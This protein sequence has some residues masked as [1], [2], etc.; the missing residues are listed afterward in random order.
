ML[1]SALFVGAF[2]LSFL[3]APPTHAESQRPT[4]K[5]AATVV[6]EL[7]R[8][9]DL[10]E[11]AGEYAE[12]AIFRAPDPGMTG[13]VPAA[14]VREALRPYRLDDDLDTA[15]LTEVA[16]TRPSRTVTVKEVEDRIIQALAG[17]RGLGA[18]SDLKLSL[19]QSLRDFNVESDLTAPLQIVRLNLDPY[20]SRFHIMLDIPGSA[21][22]R[23]T[24]LRLSGRVLETVETAV[25]ARSM[26]RGEVIRP[27]DV[28][29]ERRP[30]AEANKDG[31]SRLDNATGLAVRR[32]L[33]A[34]QALRHADLMKPEIVQRNETVTLIYEVPGIVLT[35]RGKAQEAGAQGDIIG[36][37]NL[38]SQRT[39]HGTVSGPGLVTVTS[40]ILRRDPQ[41][42]ASLEPANAPAQPE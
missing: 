29:I 4:L 11:H 17:Q 18:A 26:Q 39:V 41:K 31:V 22:L 38:Q 1:R 7:V 37:L 15:G 8:V 5:P 30:L 10:V 16:V 14:R 28:T 9:G 20:G 12:A 33:R 32:A 23:R 35:I 34:G 2:A 25:L 24:P 13:T 36:V 27:G 40:T 3:T 6:G 19:D 42:T 21:V